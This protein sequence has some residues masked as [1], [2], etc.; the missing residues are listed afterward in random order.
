MSEQPPAGSENGQPLPPAVGEILPPESQLQAR[1]QAEYLD[2]RAASWAAGENGFWRSQFQTETRYFQDGMRADLGAS[3]PS[4]RRTRIRTAAELGI[5]EVNAFADIRVGEY[6]T[7]LGDV[8]ISLIGEDDKGPVREHWFKPDG[9]LPRSDLVE[10]ELPGD[11][12]VKELI[13]AIGQKKLEFMSTSSVGF[14][15]DPELLAVL[16]N[17]SIPSAGHVRKY[18][19]IHNAQALQTIYDKLEPVMPGDAESLPAF[20]P[21]IYYNAENQVDKVVLP[22]GSLGPYHYVLKPENPADQTSLMEGKYKVGYVVDPSKF[23]MEIGNNRYKESPAFIFSPDAAAICSSFEQAGLKPTS[24]LM[25]ILKGKE[26]DRYGH[27]FSHLT[28]ALCEIVNRGNED[29]AKMFDGESLADI[30]SDIRKL[31]SDELTPSGA[32]IVIDLLRGIANR[33]DQS[34]LPP[35]INQ[36]KT[37]KIGSMCKDA[38]SYYAGAAELHQLLEVEPDNV[39]MLHKTHG[40]HTY[41]L[42]QPT[43]FNGVELPAGTIMAQMSDGWAAGRVSAYALAAKEANPVQAAI[44]VYG[45]QMEE[46]FGET[47]RKGNMRNFI[48]VCEKIEVDAA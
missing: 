19:K 17:H 3:A 5:D 45:A 32:K 43:L 15:E 42:R 25:S 16:A 22:N 38:E 36:S 44:R 26:D 29:L 33:S 34:Q 46:T 30:E 48:N 1:M 14:Q 7:K 28:F 35:S 24:A 20:A 12:V 13:D 27:A 41:M 37:K 47:N 21:G 23:A 18:Q 11:E 10:A 40:Q 39:P 31:Q 9:Q 8:E 4:M 6:A 2:E